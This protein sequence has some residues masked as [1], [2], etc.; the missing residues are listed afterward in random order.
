MLGSVPPFSLIMDPK[1]EQSALWREGGK[2][3]SDLCVTV[4]CML[5]HK[6]W[7]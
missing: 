2:V 3:S 1:A 6:V 4:N 5:F 7:S